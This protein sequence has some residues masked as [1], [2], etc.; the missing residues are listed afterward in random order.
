M[1]S[2]ARVSPG[3]ELQSPSRGLLEP[4][5]REFAHRRPGEDDALIRQAGD[6]AARAHAGQQRRSGEPYVTHPVAVAQIVAELGLDAPTVA[7]ALLHDAVEDTGVTV[8]VLEEFGPS[9]PGSSTG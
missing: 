4:V 7:A 3:D 2:L 5:L 8:A 1:V 9:S 6:L